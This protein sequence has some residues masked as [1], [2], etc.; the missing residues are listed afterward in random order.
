MEFMTTKYKKIQHAPPY[1]RV[2][3]LSV[4]KII[5]LSFYSLMTTLG[6]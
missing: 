4:Q 6:I 5:L 1:L 2:Y 3:L